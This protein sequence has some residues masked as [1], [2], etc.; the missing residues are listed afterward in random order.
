MLITSNYAEGKWSVTQNE[1]NEIPTN[2]WVGKY[3]KTDAGP[4]PKEWVEKLGHIQGEAEWHRKHKHIPT[5]ETQTAIVLQKLTD[6]LETA[7]IQP[8]SEREEI[9]ND[10]FDEFEE[11][12]A[13]QLDTPHHTCPHCGCK[14]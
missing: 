7:K 5:P 12:L 6:L 2:E 13:N 1:A 11:E 9:I 8:G 3:G 10:L 4:L 14:E